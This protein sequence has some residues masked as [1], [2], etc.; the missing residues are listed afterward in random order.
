LICYHAA[1]HNIEKPSSNLLNGI[2]RIRKNA[3]RTQCMVF[4]PPMTR[5]VLEYK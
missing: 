2:K 1:N 5:N 4:V 3:Q